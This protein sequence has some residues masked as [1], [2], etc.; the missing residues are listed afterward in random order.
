MEVADYKSTEGLA[1]ITN[2]QLVSYQKKDWRGPAHQ[3]FVWYDNDKDIKVCFPVAGL[4]KSLLA[5]S[6]D[7]QHGGL[8][9]QLR[10]LNEPE[11]GQI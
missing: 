3:S 2:L 9:A 4:N 10:Q 6:G 7:N 11:A 5:G 8:P 1:G